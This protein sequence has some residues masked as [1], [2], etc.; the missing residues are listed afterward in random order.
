MS[1]RRHYANQLITVLVALNVEMHINNAI[2]M[3]SVRTIAMLYPN[4]GL[5]H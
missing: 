3:E 1:W 2:V 5:I 4:P